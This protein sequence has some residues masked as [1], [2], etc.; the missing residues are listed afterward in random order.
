MEDAEKLVHAFVSSRLYCCNTLLVGISGQSNQ[1]LELRL[2]CCNTLLVGISG[3]SNQGLELRLYCCNTLLV[4]ISGTSNQGLELMQTSAARILMRGR[5]HEQN[6]RDAILST[7]ILKV[8]EDLMLKMLTALI[9]LMTVSGVSSACGKKEYL[10]G[11]ECCPM[12]GPGYHVWRNCIDL[13][14][15]VCAPCPTSFYTDEHNALQSCKRCTICDSGLQVKRECTPSSDTLCEP[16][17]G[18]YCTHLIKDG[19]GGAVQHTRCKPGQYVKQ[20]GT[21]STDAVCEDCEG[22]TYS[23]GSLSS[24]RPHTWCELMGLEV[25]KAGSSSHD[26]KC[27]TKRN[28]VGVIVLTVLPVGACGIMGFIFYRKKKTDKLSAIDGTR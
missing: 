26:T 2:Y 11:Q 24:C 8:V 13:S 1:G 17:E 23:N 20:P 28:H 9:L 4:G 16:L 21:A 18:H 15:T 10:I 14:S 25:L 5:K 22:D 6:F 7:A 27:G 12:C 19:C 3:K